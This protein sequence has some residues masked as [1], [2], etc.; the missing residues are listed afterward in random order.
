MEHLKTL[1]V[2]VRAGKN[3][4]ATLS[5]CTTY[6]MRNLTTV[7]TMIK[8]PLFRDTLISGDIRVGG[9]SDKIQWR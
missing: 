8:M 9:G 3:S 4:V 2:K 7:T 1:K 6:K 5:Y